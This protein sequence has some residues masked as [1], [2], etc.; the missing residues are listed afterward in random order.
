MNIPTYYRSKD[1]I[2]KNKTMQCNTLSRKFD[3]NYSFFMVNTTLCIKNN[4][5]NF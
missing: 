3:T 4:N 2:V 1:N 5:I